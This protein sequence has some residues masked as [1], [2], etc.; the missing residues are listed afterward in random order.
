MSDFTFNV[1]LGREVEF[2]S[3]VKNND[4]STSG[5][6]GMVVRAAAIEADSVL[7]DYDTFAAILGGTSDEATN[8]N[9]A[10]KVWTDADLAAYSP[11][12]ALDR[13]QLFVPSPVTWTNVA[14]GDVWAK[15]VIGYDDDTGTGTDT[16]IIPI[17]AHDILYNGS[18]LVPN[19]TNIVMTNVTGFVVCD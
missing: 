5:F 9:Y 7:K 17:T 15:F 4:P 14:S 2:Y 16:N 1:S 6:V 13:I 11:D 18:Y 12:D 3:R 8:T 10:R 19:G